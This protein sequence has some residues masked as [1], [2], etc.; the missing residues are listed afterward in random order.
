MNYYF[1]GAKI[2]ASTFFQFLQYKSLW[3]CF[4]YEWRFFMVEVFPVSVSQKLAIWIRFLSFWP[5]SLLRPLEAKLWASA[6]SLRPQLLAEN[7]S[8]YMRYCLVSLD[9]NWSTL[10][11]HLTAA[12]VKVSGES[13]DVVI[14]F[15]CLDKKRS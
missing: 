12:I 15:S 9:E 8:F 13:W 7:V 11:P 2:V 14:F 3:F 6:I 1:L 10:T 5:R 4:K